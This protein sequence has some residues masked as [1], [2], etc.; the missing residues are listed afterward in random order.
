MIKRPLTDDGLFGYDEFD[1]LTLCTIE[2]DRPDRR[3]YEHVA[4]V[5]RSTCKICNHGWQPT[6]P[7]IG[8][9]YRWDLLGDQVY[10]HLTCFVRHLGLVD[11]SDV[12]RAICDARIRFRGLVEEPNGYW[13]QTDVWGRERPWYSAE[14]IDHPYRFLIGSRKRVWSIEL[15]PQGGIKCGWWEA[16]K[17]EFKDE[18]VTKE[19]GEG[20]ILL[21][22]WTDAKLADYIKRLAKVG[23]LAKELPR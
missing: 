11:R 3:C 19:F 21:H 20:G 10:V 2:P 17:A 23:D 5:R 14:L 4:D 6:G 9:Q 7:S 8:D 13:G 22:A 16:A 18:D 15:Q 1:Q 12:R